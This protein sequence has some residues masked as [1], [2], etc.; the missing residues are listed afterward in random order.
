MW[1]ALL[2]Y[3]TANALAGAIGFVAVPILARILGPADFARAALFVSAVWV[4]NVIAGLNIGAAI[5]VKLKK[6][7]QAEL[8]VFVSSAFLCVL[9][10]GALWSIII[11]LLGEMVGPHVELSRNLLLLALLSSLFGVIFQSYQ[12][13][14]MMS[15]NA[16]AYGVMQVSNSALTAAISVALA[17]WMTQ[18]FFGRIFGLIA[19]YSVFGVLGFRALRKL[20]F[21]RFESAGFAGCRE[22]L[23]FCLPLMPHMAGVFLFSVVDRFLAVS[24]G[25]AAASGKYVAAIS[26]SA[27]LALIISASNRALIPRIYTLL[28][29]G[30]P[31]A[32][33]S[34]QRVQNVYFVVSSAAAVIG[35]L[36]ADYFAN[37]LLGPEYSG[38]GELLSILLV[39]QSVFA[40]Y[41]MGSNILM[42]YEKVSQLSLITLI[43]GLAN[44]VLIYAAFPAWGLQG[45]AWAGVT[46]MLLRYLWVMRAVKS[47]TPLGIFKL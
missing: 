38:A 36:A 19:G 32:F 16:R 3:S 15:G 39:G 31:E 22:V 28:K 24:L 4:F 33:A 23:A 13:F 11:F 44:V 7:G 10:F 18:P 25:G 20:G 34:V 21:L 14:Q 26:L 9:G 46:S 1:K 5:S 12:S 45:I 35:W 30:T 6:K 40:C 27:A 29:A 2:S 41:T 42:Y 43:C 37:A 17:F 47:I 8:E